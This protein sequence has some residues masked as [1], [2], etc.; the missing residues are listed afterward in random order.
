[1]T[2]EQ[3]V[4]DLDEDTAETAAPRRAGSRV[5]V[6]VAAAL[7][8]LLVG[9][10]AGML[11]T[12]AADD[13]A[14]VPGLASVDV[15]FCQ[16]MRFHHQQ[17][18]TMATIAGGRSSDTLVRALAYDIEGG[19]I[20]QIGMMSGWLELWERP[21]YA[22]Q[23]KHMTW[24]PADQRHGTH[25]DAG[26]VRVMPGMATQDELARLRSLSGREFDVFFLQLM[27]RHHQGG[28][29]MAKYAAEHA[30]IAVVRNLANK[31]VKAQT[32]DMRVITAMLD[33]RG[34]QPLPAPS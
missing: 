5:L 26:G 19:Q 13:E 8:L 14:G 9:A 27:L 30:A 6:Y 16:D 22:E 10:A 20:A 17:A 2:T 25:G 31:I 32:H 18:V 15:G 11:V 24:M 4:T 34:A 1:M 7:A 28:L 23:G 33:E 12:R 21:A 29:P 3:D